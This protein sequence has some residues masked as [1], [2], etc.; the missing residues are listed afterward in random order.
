MT[1]KTRIPASLAALFAD[2]IAEHAAAGYGPADAVRF[3]LADD[4][5]RIDAFRCEAATAGD[6]AG[7][8]LADQALGESHRQ[9]PAGSRWDVAGHILDAL[10]AE[11]D[12]A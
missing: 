8:A 5:D 11:H 4:D 2:A 6:D 1:S 9:G 7:H 10:C 3:A 12:D